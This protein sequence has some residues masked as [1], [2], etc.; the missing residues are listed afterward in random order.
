MKPIKNENSSAVFTVADVCSSLHGNFN[1]FFKGSFQGKL[2]FYFSSLTYL[3][4]QCLHGH[5]AFF[6]IIAIHLISQ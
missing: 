2:N 6:N 3:F 1:I 5:H 4:F